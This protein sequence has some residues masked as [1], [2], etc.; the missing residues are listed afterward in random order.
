MEKNTLDQLQAEADKIQA[1]I[2]PP[3]E[4]ATQGA[5]QANGEPASDKPAA[6]RVSISEEVDDILGLA[7]K[8][9][10]GPFPRAT[11]LWPKETRKE[12][13][14]LLQE[15]CDKYGWLQEG[16]MRG[17]G[18]EIALIFFAGTMG[19]STY[20]AVL[21]DLAAM[22]EQASKAPV[23]SEAAPAA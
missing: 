14:D 12:L 18:T 20:K 11:A 5:D 21:L 8:G 9:L 13:G 22:K 23:L 15:L 3:T 6:P 7:I 1:G 16:V 4:D 17:A 10:Q 2:T 19:Y